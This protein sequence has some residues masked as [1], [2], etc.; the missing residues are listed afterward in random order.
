MRNKKGPARKVRK[1]AIASKIVSKTFQ[2]QGF[3]KNRK[4][5]G[6]R[7]TGGG[8]AGKNCGIVFEIFEKLSSNVNVVRKQSTGG[9]SYRGKITDGDEPSK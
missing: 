8:V 2:S 7:V 4:V 9:F 6:K 1:G 3:S 5:E